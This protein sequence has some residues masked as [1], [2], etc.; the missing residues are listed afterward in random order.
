MKDVFFEPLTILSQSFWIGSLFIS[1]N[2]D[3]WKQTLFNRSLDHVDDCRPPQLYTGFN[4]WRNIMTLLDSIQLQRTSPLDQLMNVGW[5]DWSHIP[6]DERHYQQ[7]RLNHSHS[8]FSVDLV[9]GWRWI[10][11]KGLS[12]LERGWHNPYPSC[13]NLQISV[14]PAQTCRFRSAAA[15]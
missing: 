8:S 9:V 13:S 6:I 15:N 4:P 2:K 3:S 14:K 7:T 1:F 12:R 5:L 10:E 11:I